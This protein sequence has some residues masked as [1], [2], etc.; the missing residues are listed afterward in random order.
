VLSAPQMDAAAILT[1]RAPGSRVSGIGTSRISKGFW[2]ATTQA[3]RLVSGIVLTR[4]PPQS[5][6]NLLA[7]E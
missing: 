1:R 6:G 5:E 2:K 3:A 7:P 4:C